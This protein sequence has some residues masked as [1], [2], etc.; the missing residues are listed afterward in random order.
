LS[1]EDEQPIL[2][3]KAPKSVPVT[4]TPSPCEVNKEKLE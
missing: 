1:A 4:K 3:R 2:C